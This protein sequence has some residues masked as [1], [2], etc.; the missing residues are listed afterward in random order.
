MLPWDEGATVDTSRQSGTGAETQDPMAVSREQRQDKRLSEAY[1][2]EHGDIFFSMPSQRGASRRARPSQ[3]VGPDQ[4]CALQERKARVEKAE[5]RTSH[6]KPGE[7]HA[8]KR[9]SSEPP[10]TIRPTRR[11]QAASDSRPRTAYRPSARKPRDKAR[12][13]RPRSMGRGQRPEPRGESRSRARAGPP[14]T[15][16]FPR[17][18]KPRQARPR[19]KG[20]FS[21]KARCV[22]ESRPRRPGRSRAQRPEARAKMGLA[23]P[24]EGLQGLL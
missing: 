12:Y 22:P 4:G 1:P 17:S 16:R 18:L 9:S 15:T 8:A 13:T 19:R 5:G 10:Q 11:Y 3:T 6:G 23:K 14:S 24:N 2:R 7:Q 21:P 20:A